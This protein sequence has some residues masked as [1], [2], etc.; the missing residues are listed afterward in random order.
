MGFA[1][2]LFI[3][4]LLVSLTILGYYGYT[5]ITGKS[6]W[7]DWFKK[8]TSDDT[9]AITGSGVWKKPDPIKDTG[10]YTDCLIP[11]DDIIPGHVV[12][13]DGKKITEQKPI[14]CS[15]CNQYLEIADEGGCV[16]YTFDLA[17]NGPTGR[18]T[19]ACTGGL[20]VGK[21]CPKTS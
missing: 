4:A 21:T 14:K 13:Y 6:F 8:T 2:V 18:G 3:I 17:E 19:G 16:P 5:V 11:N 9:P 12:K 1:K 10:S 7:P 15:E 20:G